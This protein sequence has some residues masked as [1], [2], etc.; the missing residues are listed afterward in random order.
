MM[1]FHQNSFFTTNSLHGELVKSLDQVGI[2]QIINIPV[3]SKADLCKN[4]PGPLKNGTIIYR[5]CFGPFSRLFWPLKMFR[6]WADF[7]RV[8]KKQPTQLIHAHS[9]IVNGLIAYW[10]QHKHGVPYVVTFRNTDINI[11]LNRYPFFRRIA[12][13]ILKNAHAVVALSPA[14]A[15]IQLRRF[16]SDVQY[17]EIQKKLK[18][19]PNGIKNF[20]LDNSQ[21]KGPL[22]KTP[23]VLFVGRISINKNLKSLIQAVELLNSQGKKLKLHVIGDGPLLDVLKNQTFKAEIKFFGHVGDQKT[24]LTHYR[25]S[26]ILVVP[27]FRES[28]GLV[29]PEAMS[30]GLPVIY[31]KG[32]G[33]DGYFEDGEVG[34]SVNPGNV[35]EIAVKIN[36]TFQNYETLSRNAYNKAVIFSWSKTA[37]ELKSLYR[38]ALSH[39]L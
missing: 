19:I 17:A 27:S 35:E 39:S 30:Q 28:F 13:K 33:F 15:N 5:H 9:L 36:E 31:T 12:W 24:L 26:D 18:I 2:E 38:L 4:H 8:Y 1:V 14:Y 23:V 6:I 22:N 16:F 20:W 10:A 7:K 32:Q 37:E 29:Y 34:F 25:S 3:K 21:P 11:F